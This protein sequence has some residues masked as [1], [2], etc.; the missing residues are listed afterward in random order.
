[1]LF[2]WHVILLAKYLTTYCLYF[3]IPPVSFVSTWKSIFKKLN[4]NGMKTLDEGQMWGKGCIFK[5]INKSTYLTLKNDILL[6]QP[7]RIQS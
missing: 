1:M 2:F 5:C 7:I 3:L 4:Y 6:N